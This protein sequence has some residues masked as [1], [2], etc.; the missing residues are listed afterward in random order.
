MRICIEINCDSAAL[1]EDD[2]HVDEVELHRILCSVPPKVNQQLE[3][4][5]CLCDAPEAAD[6]LLDINGNTIGT[7]KVIH[8]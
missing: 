4:P 3:R 8:D 6:K 7:L 5:P 2:D 1:F